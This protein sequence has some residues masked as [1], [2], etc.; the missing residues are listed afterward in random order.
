MCFDILKRSVS[1]PD[2]DFEQ[3]LHILL[4]FSVPFGNSKIKQLEKVRFPTRFRNLVALYGDK[5]S[6]L[7]ELLK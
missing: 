4:L 7:T 5:S 3:K 1:L 6:L 2:P